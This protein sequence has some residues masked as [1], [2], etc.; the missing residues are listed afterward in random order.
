RQY[1][2]EISGN[3]VDFGLPAMIGGEIR[4]VVPWLR[5]FDDQVLL[6]A[7]NTD[8][9]QTRSAWVDV[10]SNENGPGDRL[11]CIYSTQREQEG[12]EIQVQQVGGRLAVMIEVPAA[13]FVIFEK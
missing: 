7:I 9:D 6:C 10:P 11:R 2:R 8:P 4:S 3:G 12:R 5:L 13:G 1:L